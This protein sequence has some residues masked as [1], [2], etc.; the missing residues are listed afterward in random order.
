MRYEVLFFS[1]IGKF[2][3]IIVAVS[4]LPKLW[5]CFIIRKYRE[6]I[7]W[8]ERINNCASLSLIAHYAVKF[9][10]NTRCT[11]TSRE[12]MRIQTRTDDYQ[13]INQVKSFCCQHTNFQMGIK[14]IPQ[15]I[16]LKKSGCVVEEKLLYILVPKLLRGQLL[17]G[18]GSF[19]LPTL[20]LRGI[21]TCMDGCWWGSTH[22]ESSLGTC[23]P[24]YPLSRPVLAP[25]TH[26][27]KPFSSSRD[28]TSIFW[29]KN[30]ISQA[31]FL[32]NFG[33]ILAPGT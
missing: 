20:R 11:N 16:F 19:F 23:R 13:K 17:L 7:K 6:R 28:P 10:D 4:K 25:E 14:K 9:R 24:Q 31:Q 27:F 15:S 3:I 26:H 33:L 22:I 18:W 8:R 30:C 29:K 32:M 21:P 1:I 12:A 5:H 2:S